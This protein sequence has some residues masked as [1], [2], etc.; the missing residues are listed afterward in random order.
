MGWGAGAVVSLV[1]LGWLAARVFTP[2]VGP[3]Q[4]TKMEASAG[5]E[6]MTGARAKSASRAQALLATVARDV[7]LP[8]ATEGQLSPVALQPAAKAKTQSATMGQ[9]TR[10]ARSGTSAAGGESEASGAAMLDGV[11]VARVTV[12]GGGAQ[13]LTPNTLGL[14]PRVVVQVSEKV[15]V[16]VTYAAAEPGETVVIQMLDGGTLDNGTLSK[17]MQLDANRAVDFAAIMSV[18]E[19]VHRVALTCGADRKELE[20][21]AG[22]EPPVKSGQ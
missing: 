13:E 2:G 18:Q 8:S 9:R 17:V 4:A 20:F 14:F 10:S 22:A 6:R 12:V 7:A 21:W 1:L 15:P 19:G 16:T 3:E 5:A 11:A